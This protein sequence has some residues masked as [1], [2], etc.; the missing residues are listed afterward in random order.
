MKI[1][2]KKIIFTALLSL[3]MSSAALANTEQ[4][5]SNGIIAPYGDNPNIF[6]VFA[7]KTQENV[8]EGAH[9][10][11]EVTSSGLSKVKPSLSEAWGNTKNLVSRGSEEVKSSSQGVAANIS[12]KIHNP[13]EIIYPPTTPEDEQPA[14]Q[15]QSLSQTNTPQAASSPALIQTPNT[16]KTYAVSDL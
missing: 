2:T 16:A 3:G 14:I 6:H 8:I 1:T 11:A 9:K 5:Q 4:Q 7:Y 12:E 15:Q 13:K 10:V